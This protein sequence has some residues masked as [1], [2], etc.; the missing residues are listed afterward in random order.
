[1]PVFTPANG[2]SVSPG[3]LVLV[4]DAVARA[5]QYLVQ[6]SNETNG[7]GMEVELPASETS[8]RIPEPVAA[9]NSEYSAKILVVFENGNRNITINT[10]S[11]TQ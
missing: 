8:L 5:D 4:W 9:P 3:D 2:S 7:A 11:T 6:V 1:M 10:F